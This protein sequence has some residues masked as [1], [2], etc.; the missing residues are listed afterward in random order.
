[1]MTILMEICSYYVIACAI[2]NIIIFCIYFIKTFY[3]LEK[4]NLAKAKQFYV[5][6]SLMLQLY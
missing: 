1:M 5:K 4:N 2:E 6:K 3:C